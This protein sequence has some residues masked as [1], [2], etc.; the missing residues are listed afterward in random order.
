MANFDPSLLQQF[1]PEYYRRLFPFKLLCKW[2]TYGKDLSASFQMRELAFIFEDD[3]HA[4]YRSFEDA[5]ELEKELCKASPQKL[6]IGAIY[7]HKPKDHKKFADFCPVE[8]ELVFDIDLTDYDDIRTCCSEAKVCRKCWRWISLAVGILSYLLEKHFGFKHC[9][10]VFSG[11]RGIHCW[12]ADAVARKLQ[13][14]G[15]AAVVEYL[16]LVMSAQKISKAATKRSFVHPMLEDAYRFLVQSHDVSEMMYEQGW[17]SDDGLMSLLDGCGNKEVEEEIR[18]IINEIKTIDCHEKRWNALRIKFDNYKRAEL[19][20]NGI[21]LCE[22]ASSQ[23]SFHFRG[24]LLQRTYPRLDIHVSTGINHLLKSP[25]C[26]HPKTGLV[27]VPISP[28]QIS[29]IDIEKLPR[30]DKLLHEVPKLD[31]LEAGKEN[32]R[33]YEIKQ[34]SLGPYIKHFEEFVDRL[35]YDEQQQR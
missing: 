33:R 19:K 21:E 12:V 5:T 22:V 1:L 8:R 20:R 31:L 23:S 30:I 18:Q 25:F 27:A 14:S 17:M 28:N 29:Q 16:S 6:D 34:T 4:R 3:R 2:L 26:V 11:R 7:N 24:Y 10:W 35:V 9:C 13:N 15:R 32:E